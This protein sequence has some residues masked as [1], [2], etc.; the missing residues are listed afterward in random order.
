MATMHR[1]PPTALEESCV[2]LAR[3]DTFHSLNC[4]ALR[5]LTTLWP[6]DAALR[7]AR[8]TVPN[9]RACPWS[10]P[11]RRAVANVVQPVEE[12]RVGSCGAPVRLRV[13]GSEG[14]AHLILVATGLAH[15]HTFMAPEGK[16]RAAV[17]S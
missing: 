1:L 2:A 5:A 7:P 17:I 4:G 16:L 12:C 8:R 14:V 3:D 11:G 13:R 10:S 6:A 9:H 15:M